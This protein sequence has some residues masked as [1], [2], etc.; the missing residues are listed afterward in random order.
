MWCAMMIG[1]CKAFGF[2]LTPLCAPQS[3]GVLSVRH[4]TRTLAS[5]SA[6]ES[7]AAAAATTTAGTVAGTTRGGASAS[8]K[9]M[10]RSGERE[11]EPT[12]SQTDRAAGVY[13]AALSDFDFLNHSYEHE[14]ADHAR[15]RVQGSVTTS[16]GGGGGSVAGAKVG[17]VGRRGGNGTPP[18][19]EADSPRQIPSCSALSLR[20]Q[21]DSPPQTSTM[22]VKQVHSHRPSP[23]PP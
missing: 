6:A 3:L 9:N 4:G 15:R 11:S 10:S 23:L 2:L 14:G 7:P 13:T 16:A 8:L 19:V 21:A 17:G 20:C 18:N 22:W 12:V 5:P 1:V